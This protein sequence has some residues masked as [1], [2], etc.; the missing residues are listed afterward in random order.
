[1]SPMK[2]PLHRAVRPVQHR[3]A[4]KTLS[5]EV[6]NAYKTLVITVLVMVVSTSVTY[7]YVNSLKPAKGYL[8]KQ[9]QAD[10]D[11]LESI[12]GR[13]NQEVIEAQSFIHIQNSDVLR[14]MEVAQ[15][16]D[17]AYIDESP[18]AEAGGSHRAD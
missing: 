18:V 5:E 7:L 12:Q 14:R 15:K 3:R 8:L 10:Y 11:D 17:T 13:L 4:K 2:S 9:L 1:M 6:R 16:G